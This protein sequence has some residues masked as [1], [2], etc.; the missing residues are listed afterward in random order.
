MENLERFEQ[1][2]AD[3]SKKCER[4]A[5]WAF[6]LMITL[7][8]AS[9]DRVISYIRD[10]S[11]YFCIAILCFVAVITYSYYTYMDRVINAY[12]EIKDRSPYV[13]SQ[14][15]N[16]RCQV[17]GLLL[18]YIYIMA[19]LVYKTND[20]VRGNSLEARLC[21][22]VIIFTFVIVFWKWLW[23]LAL[24]IKYAFEDW[25]KKKKAS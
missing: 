25:M 17:V 8:A 16:F 15:R 2:C 18:G 4:M 7:F 14:Y 3:H 13:K 22:L 5:L 23:L 12:V 11:W 19:W 24:V 1:A 10:A 20:F 21:I 6:T 9:Q